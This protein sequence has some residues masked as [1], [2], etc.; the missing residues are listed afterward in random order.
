[1]A[2]RTE[3]P[4]RR[5]CAVGSSR[6][7]FVR[8]AAGFKLETYALLFNAVKRFAHVVVTMAH[9]SW[10]LVASI[11]NRWL[12]IGRLHALRDLRYISSYRHSSLDTRSQSHSFTYSLRVRSFALD[13]EGLR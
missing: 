10:Q 11:A 1:L 3:R 5:H 8:K 7:V 13:F 4:L 2:E 9:S 6:A 12:A